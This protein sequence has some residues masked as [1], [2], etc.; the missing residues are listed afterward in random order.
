MKRRTREILDRLGL[1]LDPGAPVARLS[2]AQRQLAEIARVFLG[3]PK[4]VILDEPT[5]SLA[6]AEVE[7]LFKAVRT[8]AEDGVAVI[9][10][11]HRMEEIRQIASAA[12]IM[13]DGRVADTV[14]VAGTPTRD[15]V[16]LM[17]GH[18]ESR[19]EAIRADPRL[20]SAPVVLRTSASLIRPS[21]KR[22]IWS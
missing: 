18:D 22:S 13:R 8:L 3:D 20:A 7:L 1:D 15:I 9:Y 4:L 6:A 14:D 16:R 12:T 21:S 2:P 17:L 11:S 19:D 5:S 10:V